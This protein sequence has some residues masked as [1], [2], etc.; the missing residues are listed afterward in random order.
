M[1]T[2]LDERCYFL[3]VEMVSAETVIRTICYCVFIIVGVIGNSLVC[4]SIRKRK[5]LRTLPNYLVFSLAVSDLLFCITVVPFLLIT[6]IANE[7]ILGDALCQIT[8]FLTT[9][10][11]MVSIST[12]VLISINRYI[13]VGRPTRYA[14]IFNSKRVIVSI[15][16][17]WLL[18]IAVALPPVLGWSRIRAGDNFCTIDGRKDISYAGFV[19]LVAYIIPLLTLI[20][21][22]TRIFLLLRRHANE[23]SKLRQHGTVGKDYDDYSS[24]EVGSL[25]RGRYGTNL[26]SKH[27]VVQTDKPIHLTEQATKTP[28]G[29]AGVADGGAPPVEYRRSLSADELAKYV[30]D[31]EKEERRRSSSLHLAQPLSSSN[32]VSVENVD[33]Q[34]LMIYRNKLY[35]N[36]VSIVDQS[37]TSVKQR[38]STNLSQEYGMEEPGEFGRGSEARS[39]KLASL[40]F[41]LRRKVRPNLRKMSKDAKL[42]RMLFAVVAVFFHLLDSSR[43]S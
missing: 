23:M 35:V 5:K 3:T 25:R 30:D 10:F 15:C 39:S 26:Q 42:T 1:V 9:Y 20:V 37:T 8:G 32:A 41:A 18:G 38:S 33:V 19:I 24:S 11:C 17:I 27:C 21:L 43:G 34:G 40:A 36:N 7:W 29:N 6:A 12:L 4:L 13:A 22:Y 14:S 16:I 2:I 31:D 28:N